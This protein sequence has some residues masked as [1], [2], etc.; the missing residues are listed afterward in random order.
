MTLCYV[1]QYRDTNLLKYILREICIIFQ[2]PVIRKP[3]YI[4]VML[5]QMYI[6]DTKATNLVL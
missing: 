1:I 3:K 2:L 5:G 4:R 6:F